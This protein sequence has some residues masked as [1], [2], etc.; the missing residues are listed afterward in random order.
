MSPRKRILIKFI[1]LCNQLNK[2]FWVG[3]NVL[4]KLKKDYPN[5]NYGLATDT[6]LTAIEVDPNNPNEVT[7][8][9]ENIPV[10]SYWALDFNSCYGGWTIIEVNEK[11]GAESSP[12]SYKRYKTN[13]FM[14]M[15]EFADQVN[16]YKKQ[17]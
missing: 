7:E 5:L 3:S 9:Q 8:Y 13:T 1:R 14:E 2:P 16:E 4:K 10:E 17:R 11:N 6:L 15:L 12:F